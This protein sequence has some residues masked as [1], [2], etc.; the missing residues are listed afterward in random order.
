MQP[1]SSN[2]CR[3]RPWL[4]ALWILLWVVP[5]L[6]DPGPNILLIL[7]DDQGWGDVGIHGNTDIRTPQLDRLAREG[8]LFEHFYVCPVCAPTRAELL[9]GRYHSRSGVFGVTRGEERLSLDTLTLAEHLQ[10][11]GYATGCFGK[12]HNGAQY[13]YHPNGRGFD[14][15]YGFCGGHLN[16][17]F[18]APLEHNGVATRGN[19][20]VID[21]LTNHAIQF[22]REHRNEPF[23]CYVPYNTPHTPW[24]VPDSFWHAVQE[25]GVT[26][27]ETACAYAMVENVDHNV[28]RLLT[29]L[30]KMELTPRTL[31]IFLS[32][33][34]PNSARWNGDMKG[35]KGSVHEGGIRVPC[36]MRWPGKIEPRRVAT[37]VAAID[38]LP[39]LMQLAGLEPVVQLDGLSLAGLLTRG[40]D[41]PL[42][43]LFTTWARR[44]SMRDGAFRAT[45]KE[46]Y[47][48]DE[49]PHQQVN[50]ARK[51]PRYH[52][53]L[54]AAIETWSQDVGVSKR[55][56]VPIPVGH[57]Q[58][59][60]TSLPGH[61]ARLIGAP[62]GIRYSHKSGWAN[63]WISG[64]HDTGAYA[65]WPIDVRRAGRYAVRLEMACAPQ[66]VGAR[67]RIDGGTTPLEVDIRDAL[68]APAVPSPDRIPR[69]EVGERN[70]D[71]LEAGTLDLDAGPGELVVRLVYCPGD[72]GPELKSITL[73]RIEP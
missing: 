14:E 29:A 16:N 52:A 22:I 37:P 31:V 34:G 3:S 33:N 61:E 38:L 55:V 25:R 1:S 70:W 2:R 27:P 73:T 15:F 28:G 39:T 45:E 57:S 30:E 48:L 12:W 26:P 56:P 63:D 18:D 32:D 68:D 44:I 23:L 66:D 13:P 51:M 36:F 19:G 65:S 35:R 72:R 9:T 71:V 64:W 24:Q 54:V 62:D 58:R 60:F 59:P 50:V 67:L 17:Y 69:K 46:L 7:T 49:D 6:A 53:R 11:A 20:F 47:N 8:I 21:D 4:V 42:R 10:Q 40:D 43:P 5:V 41:L